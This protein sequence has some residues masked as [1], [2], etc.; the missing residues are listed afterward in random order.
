MEQLAVKAQNPLAIPTYNEVRGQAVT[1]ALRAA[2]AAATINLLWNGYHYRGTQSGINGGYVV[3]LFVTEDA[4]Q[5][6]IVADNVAETRHLSRDVQGNLEESTSMLKNLTTERKELA[7][8]V[9]SLKITHQEFEREVECLKRTATH[10]EAE[11][12]RLKRIATHI[13]ASVTALSRSTSQL[14]VS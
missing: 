12:E 6:G 10:I 14:N 11:V 4:A 3:V 9:E 2:I 5:K 13:E 1:L 7:G 8:E